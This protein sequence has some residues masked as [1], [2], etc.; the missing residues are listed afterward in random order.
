[1]LRTRTIHANKTGCMKIQLWIRRTIQ[2][3]CGD[4]DDARRL[5]S[6]DSFCS[7]TKLC[8]LT[9]HTHTNQI[10]S[11]ERFVSGKLYQI[12][13]TVISS[14]FSLWNHCECTIFVRLNA[15]RIQNAQNIECV[16]TIISD[17]NCYDVFN[18]CARL[19]SRT[20]ASKPFHASISFRWN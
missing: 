3:D 8:T 19:G 18:L 13:D 17:D 16:C 4:D 1:M 2:L 10:K 14:S 15:L 5:L 7:E 20:E 11:S 12:H 6:F 9:P